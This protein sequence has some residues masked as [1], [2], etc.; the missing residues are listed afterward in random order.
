MKS[1]IAF[2]FTAAVLFSQSAYAFPGICDK[3]FIGNGETVYHPNGQVAT[4]FAGREGATWYHSNGETFT[5]FAGRNGATTYHSN[6]QTLTLFTG[7]EGATW[8]WQ[9]GQTLSLF[10]GRAGATWYYDNGSVWESR[11]P[12]LTSRQMWEYACEL[13]LN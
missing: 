9:N 1:S 6:G 11:G 5:L 12:A 7:R 3:M 10:M 13:A 8:Y 2:I 4:L